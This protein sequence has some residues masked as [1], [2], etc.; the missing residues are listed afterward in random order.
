MIRILFII[1]ILFVSCNDQ[2]T[3]E[4]PSNDLKILDLKT[5]KLMTPKNWTFV[6]TIGID[7]YVGRIAIGSGDTLLFD[8]GRYRCSFGNGNRTIG[9]DTFDNRA[10]RIIRPIQS[11]KGAIGFQFDSINPDY[12]KLTI[13]GDSLDIENESKFLNAVRT[14]S[15]VTK[16]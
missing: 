1:F 10:V 16:K 2:K 14:I 3:V 13:F 11:G 12:T 4:P 15:F 5:F 8:Y 9:Y 7:S 6:K